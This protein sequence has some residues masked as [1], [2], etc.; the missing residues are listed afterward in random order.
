M[1]TESLAGIRSNRSV[2]HRSVIQNPFGMQIAE[3]APLTVIVVLDGAAGVEF[4]DG[5][6]V[7]LALHEVYLVC[8]PEPYRL[9]DAAASPT[10]LIVEPSGVR[11]PDG[12]ALEPSLDDVRCLIEAGEQPSSTVL[13]GNYT[14][15]AGMGRR[16]IAA[17]PRITGVRLPEMAS[18]LTLF[19]G[20]LAQDSPGR[21]L[22]LDRWLDLLMTS[23]L[24]RWAYD[25]A[26]G[27]AWSV[28]MVDPQIGP[29]LRAMHE[30]PQEPW[31]LVDLAARASMS[32]SAFTSRFTTLVRQPPMRYLAQLR[33]DIATD[34]LVRDQAPL[35]S[36]ARAV[37]YADPF[38][39]SAAYKRVRGISPAQ[40]RRAAS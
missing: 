6:R 31:T 4:P 35:A 24:R 11:T 30:A 38:G 32:R 13:S 12:R 37:G 25:E 26:T 22:V 29:A 10:R 34:L 28:A 33:M 27:P 19:E 21:Q 7:E 18:L 39:F 5:E 3:A 9:A 15:T 16:I 40:V 1:L 8:H 36:I 17:L 20:E 14:A 23:A 2:L